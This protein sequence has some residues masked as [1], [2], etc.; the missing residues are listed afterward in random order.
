[1]DVFERLRN[2]LHVILNTPRPALDVTELLER[3]IEA[4]DHGEPLRRLPRVP[5]RERLEPL[6]L[7]LQLTLVLVDLK[8]TK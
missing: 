6:R 3:R 4:L 5:R 2:G 1:M 8:N 7:F